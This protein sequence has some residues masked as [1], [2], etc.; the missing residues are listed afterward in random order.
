MEQ[1]KNLSLPS[2]GVQKPRSDSAFGNKRAPG[3]TENLLRIGFKKNE[4][5]VGQIPEKSENSEV[6]NQ[7]NQY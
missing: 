3:Q 1:I 4:T 5:F 6:T 7:F 2:K